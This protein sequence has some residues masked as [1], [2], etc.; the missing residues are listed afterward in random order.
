VKNLY[1]P[2]VFAL[3]FMFVSLAATT[4]FAQADAGVATSIPG[5]VASAPSS[6]CL[7]AIEAMESGGVC[8]PAAFARVNS[9]CNA[10]EDAAQA[11]FETWARAHGCLGASEDAPDIHRDSTSTT[12][13]DVGTPPPP[14]IRHRTVVD[15]REDLGAIRVGRH[16]VCAAREITFADGTTRTVPRFPARVEGSST[17]D[18][19]GTTRTTHVSV[20]CAATEA[21][22]EVIATHIVEERI[23][24][25]REALEALCRPT[26]RTDESLV[27]ACRDLRDRIDRIRPTA[28]YDDGW[29]RTELIAIRDRLD[30]HECR[31]MRLERRELSAECRERGFTALPDDV[32]PPSVIRSGERSPFHFDLYGEGRLVLRMSGMVSGGGGVAAMLRGELPNTG[33]NLQL[34]GRVSVGGGD[35]GNGVGAAFYATGGFGLYGVAHRFVHLYGGFTASGWFQPGED[36]GAYEG[37]LRSYSLGGEFHGRF[38]LGNPHVFIDLG[39]AVNWSPTWWYEG[40]NRSQDRGGRILKYGGVSIDPSVGIGFTF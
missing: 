19:E 3:M 21:A 16:C 22:V 24:G 9:E 38:Y 23:R 36:R 15:C 13:P 35:V 30:D 10:S 1:A 29:I 28:S 6:R 4:A 32:A 27:R 12:T 39:I 2:F 40:P 7:Q 11:R 17:V 33:G 18:R 20:G 37:P 14:R 26:D 25:H 8:T 34:Y 5:A 31:I